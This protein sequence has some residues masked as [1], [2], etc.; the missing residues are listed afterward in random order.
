MNGFSGPAVL[1][2]SIGGDFGKKTG[3]GFYRWDG[4]RV[5]SR[6][7]GFPDEPKQGF[8]PL[9]REI[10]ARLIGA[11]VREA[12]A[13]LADGL[14]PVAEEVDIATIFGIGFPPFRG[15]ALRYGATSG[16]GEGE[17]RPGQPAS[18]GMSTEAAP[19]RTG[20]P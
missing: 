18:T 16:I 3:R 12:Q 14:V 2:L 10:V 9:P 5:P 8:M 11:M 20:T 4:A 6:S 19:V 13:A 17:P 15:G 7:V 1:R